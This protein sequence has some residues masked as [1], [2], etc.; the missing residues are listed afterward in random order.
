MLRRLVSVLTAGVLL[1]LAAVPVS[2]SHHERSE[3][4]ASIDGV[5][6]RSGIVLVGT[7][8]PSDVLRITGHDPVGSPTAITISV[9]IGSA[10]WHVVAS[11]PFPGPLEVWPESVAS[12]YDRV[13]F[14][15]DQDDATLTFECAHWTDW[16]TDLDGVFDD[17]DRCL[18]TVWPDVFPERKADRYAADQSGTLRSLTS[19][20]TFAL[21][22][23]GGCSARQIIAGAGLGKGHQRYGLSKE[24]LEAWIASLGTP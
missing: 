15:V 19:A 23:T 22:E 14:D 2:A 1:G 18:G 5:T 24:A 20:T 10:N 12:G 17:R 3:L 13:L 8:G 9:E 6:S 16:D 21:R 11:A 7:W 4:C